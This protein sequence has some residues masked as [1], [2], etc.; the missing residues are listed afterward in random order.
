MAPT[1]KTFLH[2]HILQCV[3]IVTRLP[4]VNFKWRVLLIT[5]GVWAQRDS[6]I[7]AC[8]LNCRRKSWEV[9]PVSAGEESQPRTCPLWHWSKHWRISIEGQRGENIY[10]VLSIKSCWPWPSSLGAPQ[11]SPRNV[12]S[13]P[14]QHAQTQCK[15]LLLSPSRIL[16]YAWRQADR[17]S[18]SLDLHFSVSIDSS[19]KLYFFNLNLLS[20]F[21]TN[22]SITH[23]THNS[24]LIVPRI[25]ACS[26]SNAHHVKVR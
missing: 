11:W 12:C 4:W 3:L 24:H 16:F 15:V 8:W 18:G 1:Y 20:R 6:L 5:N 13:N 17:G 22:D 23:I 21:M 2:G 9:W 7:E 19:L 14:R 25:S 26:F 10:D